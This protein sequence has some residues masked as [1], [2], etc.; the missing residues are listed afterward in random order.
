MGGRK[1]GQNRLLTA[2]QERQI[3]RLIQDKTPDQIEL[4]YALWSRAAVANLILDQF[5][6]A[7]A[8]R[9][10]GAYLKRLG[11]I[12]QKPLRRAYKQSQAEV[13]QWMDTPSGHCGAR[14]AGRC[15][16]PLGATVP[17]CA[18]TM[19]TVAAFT[20]K[21]ETPVIPVNSK[22]EGLSI[23]ST[24]TNKGQMR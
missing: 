11:F 6:I 24:V 19:C 15:R 2:E 3:Q 1:L 17:G 23:I 12:P 5:G 9:T 7:V 16:N 14:E 18:A 10:M 13:K 21:G 20:P 8:V 22:Q 4:P